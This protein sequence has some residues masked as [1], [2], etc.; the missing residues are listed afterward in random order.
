MWEGA[1]DLAAR[2]G[3]DTAIAAEALTAA[4]YATADRLAVSGRETDGKIRDVRNYLF[5]TYM[6]RI[7]DIARKQSPS[8][9]NYVDMKNWV[10]NSRLS[11]NWNFLEGLENDDLLS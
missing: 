6:Y 8:Q 3:V 4:T 10:A 2:Y 7:F 9:A 1:V 11:D 5:A